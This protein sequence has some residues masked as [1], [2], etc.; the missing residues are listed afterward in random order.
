MLNVWGFPRLTNRNFTFYTTTSNNPIH[1]LLNTTFQQY[2]LS[3]PDPVTSKHLNNTFVSLLRSF[4][5]VYKVRKHH[6][7]SRIQ[8]K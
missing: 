1:T 5:C 6:Y 8:L 4:K 3:K 7:N 2:Q